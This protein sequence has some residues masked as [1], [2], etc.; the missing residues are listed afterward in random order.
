M[1]EPS[2]AT[3]RAAGPTG[4]D[5]P[6]QVPAPRHIST[7]PFPAAPR[8]PPPEPNRQSP[9]AHAALPPA[10]VVPARRRTPR[11]WQVA[12]GL[13]LLCTAVLAASTTYLWRTSDA[14]EERA[15]DYE[16]VSRDLG[17]QLADTKQELDSTMGE[18]D[19]VSAQLQTAQT[20]IIELADEKA[21][22][23]DDREAQ[24]LLADYQERVTEAAGRVA[25]ALDQC[26]QG[27]NQLIGYLENADLYDPADLDAYATD[28]QD[29]CQAATDANTALQSELAR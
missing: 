3:V 28:V 4:P 29:L 15:G 12:T 21:Q 14:W 11:R 24:R 7:S 2:D 26:V 10:A 5:A 13:L 20:R 27:Q 17:A 18:L 16:A 23:G 9:A 22:I 19:A 6:T 1:T 8:I 25:L